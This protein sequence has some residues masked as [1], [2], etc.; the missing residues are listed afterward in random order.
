[1]EEIN[2]VNP[3]PACSTDFTDFQVHYAG[4]IELVLLPN[5]VTAESIRARAEPDHTAMT[6]RLIEPAELAASRTWIENW[7]RILPCLITTRGLP[8]SSLLTA[9][10]RFVATARSLRAI[11]RGFSMGDPLV[12][13][14]GVFNLLHVGCVSTAELHT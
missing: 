9:I 12:A 14:A 4:R 10:E 1:M 5:P 3:E 11:E 6:V 8:S 7:Q 2:V 13:R